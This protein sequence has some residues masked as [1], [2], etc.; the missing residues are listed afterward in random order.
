MAYIS[1]FFDAVETSPDV[2]DRVYPAS[3]FARRFEVYFKD[4]I[5]LDDGT[6]TTELEVTANGD[7]TT[8]V[9]LGVANIKGYTVEVT[10]TVETVTHSTADPT[11]DR[12][13]RVV[14]QLSNDPSI[15]FINILVK[16]GTPSATPTAPALT[17]TEVS[18][19]YTWELSLAQ[20][21]I[22][23]GDTVID[24]GDITDERSDSSVCGISDLTISTIDANSVVVDNSSFINLSGTDGQTV[25]EEIDAKLGAN[26][27][28]SLEAIGLVDAD[29]TGLGYVDGMLLL[30]NNIPNNS[31]FQINCIGNLQSAV[32]PFSDTYKTQGV[33]KITKQTSTIYMACEYFRRTTRDLTDADLPSQRT[34]LSFYS[35]FDVTQTGNDRWAGWRI[36]GGSYLEN[37]IISPGNSISRSAVET[38]N[39][40]I[41]RVR[42]SPEE[43]NNRATIVVPRNKSD[44][45]VSCKYGLQNLYTAVK[46]NFFDGTISNSAGSDTNTRIDSITCI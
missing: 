3:Y 24:S 35:S 5:V 16:E 19:I 37:V 29:F 30:W 38:A 39:A 25:F 45:L 21:Y 23:A 36:A 1:S 40:V 46:V 22:T 13:D 11:L 27:Y 17:R 44:Q 10:P 26:I 2:F 28:T 12:I 4:G 32:A 42:I 14:L 8:T 6:L 18:G 9:N 20:V 7:M 33:L 41:V 43:E 31:I 34:G 15:R